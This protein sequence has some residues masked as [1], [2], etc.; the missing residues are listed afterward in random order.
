MT[1][2]PHF[3]VP[4]RVMNG[5]VATVEQ[6]SDDDILACVET[7]LRTPVGNREEQPD[8]DITDLTFKT[9]PAEIN[10]E[11]QQALDELEPRAHAIPEA[12]I[13]ELIATVRIGAQIG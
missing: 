1:D 6:D 12:E 10:L 7:V 5:G 2:I 11:C 8:F 13:N 9:D 3:A 4:F